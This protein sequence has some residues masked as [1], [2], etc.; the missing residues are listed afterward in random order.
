MFSKLNKINILYFRVMLK[1]IFQ[2]WIPKL[3]LMKKM[4]HLKKKSYYKKKNS[5]KE[6]LKS[7]QD[8]YKV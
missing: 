8:F 3:I 5:G 2:I 7:M 6:T 4:Q 1:H